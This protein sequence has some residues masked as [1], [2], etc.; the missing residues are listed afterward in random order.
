MSNEIATTY[1][2]ATTCLWLGLVIMLLG[3]AIRNIEDNLF[4]IE[5][6]ITGFLMFTF[7]VFLQLRR[8]K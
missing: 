8:K 3:L 4:L 1:E 6:V 7:L 5:I 2:I